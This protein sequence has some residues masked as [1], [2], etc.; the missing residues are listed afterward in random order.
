[1]FETLFG[2]VLA[3]PATVA[4]L[5]LASGG[6]GWLYWRLRAG[7]RRKGE[8]PVETGWVPYLGC[9]IGFGKHAGNYLKQCQ[10]KHGDT[11]TLIIAG[12]RMT[13]VLD[14]RDYHTVLHDYK[15]VLSFH[16]LAEDISARAFSHPHFD[17]LPGDYDTFAN[18][19]SD[20]LKGSE[21]IEL[22]VSMQGNLD[23]VLAQYGE[24]KWE[25]MSLYDFVYRAMFVAGG[26]TVFGKGFYTPEV[27]E[28]FRLLD[29]KFPLLIAGIPHRL[30]GSKQALVTL[31][32]HCA[33]VYPEAAR[34]T[35]E[36]HALME[37]MDEPTKGAFQTAILWALQANT[38]PATFW[39][40]AY[41]L[42]DEEALA[43]VR[44][45]IESCTHDA[46]DSETGSLTLNRAILKKMVR[47]DSAISEALRLSTGSMTIRRVLRDFDMPLASGK[48]ISLR[49][50]S[51]VALYPYLVHFD[52]D[53]YK[54]PETYQFE[55]FYSE[56]K[57]KAFH[58]YGEKLKYSL[59]PFGGGIS[60]CPGRHFARNE[61]KLFVVLMLYHFD[62]EL[63][64]SAW[65]QLDQTRA[66]LGILPPTHD[67][68]FRLRRRSE[69]S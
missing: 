10:S 47:L 28:A 9:A 42:Q 32:E 49:K 30:T 35:L 65:P 16:E 40:L 17:G 1:M 39:S 46:I 4:S 21:L 69:A 50:D 56:G 52:P 57:P 23:D 26:H 44:S 55:R 19:T 37:E 12:Q 64:K 66:G 3:H 54:E 33:N 48:T 45:E 25:E 2:F 61:I 24:D 34:L 59:M 60:I 5:V 62:L 11:F 22:T 31:V 8:P 20:S 14:P 29:E 13:F 41:L 15:D 53:I 68:P 18:I 43:A 58:K 38:I 36:R 51:Q 7:S 67:I 27:M 6:M 63:L